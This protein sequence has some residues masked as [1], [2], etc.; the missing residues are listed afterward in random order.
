MILL[1]KLHH[2]PLWLAF[3][4]DAKHLRRPTMCTCCTS[5]TSATRVVLKDIQWQAWTV[6]L[7]AVAA[8]VVVVAAAGLVDW[9]AVL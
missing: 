8:A 3:C 6:Q 2:L 9:P 7:V 1:P 4:G 5:G